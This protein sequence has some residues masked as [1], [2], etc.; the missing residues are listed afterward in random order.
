[1]QN[2][3]NSSFT[4]KQREISASLNHFYNNPIAR[5]S[6]ELFLTIGLVLFLAVFAIK[7]TLITMSDLIKEIESKKKLEQQLTQKVAALQTAQSQYFTIE[8]KLPILSEAIPEQPQIILSAKLIEKIA[9]DSKVIIRNMSIIEI[10]PE[11]DGQVPFSQ[12]AKQNLSITVGVTAD[13]IAIRDFVENLKNSRKSFVV[14]SV[15]FSL[16][17]EKGSKKL[18]A[19]LTINAPYFGKVISPEA[20]GSR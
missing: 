13:Y 8:E 18:S 1:M 19:N 11:D 2:T 14:E 5:V 10:P 16:E 6:L 9:A 7:P 17:E 20:K 15:V 3:T 12:K 4:K